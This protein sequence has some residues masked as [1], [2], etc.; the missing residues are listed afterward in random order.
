[1]RNLKN[2]TNESIYKTESQSSETNLPLP[3]GIAGGGEVNLKFW[4]NM[5]T[6]YIIKSFPYGSADKESTCNA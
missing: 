5:Y 2:N 4:I 3:K 6:L 1:M